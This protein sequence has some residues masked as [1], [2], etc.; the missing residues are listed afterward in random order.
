MKKND[1]NKR[2]RA[3]NEQYQ[4]VRF[5]K[6]KQLKPE[7]DKLSFADKLKFL[8]DNFG[9][10]Y[11]GESGQSEVNIAPSGVGEISVYPDSGN[12][13]EIRFWNEWA[14]RKYEGF[15]NSLFDDYSFPRLK[16]RFQNQIQKIR[17]SN[18]FPD[19]LCRE[20]MARQLK[21]YSE[22][23]KAPLIQREIEYYKGNWDLSKKIIGPS[24]LFARSYSNYVS[25]LKK[26]IETGIP[27]DKPVKT[28][29]DFLIN[30]PDDKKK[31]FADQLSKEFKTEIGMGIRYMIEGLKK[32]NILVT[33]NRQNK[34]LFDAITNY[35]GR[36]IGTYNSV[37]IP[38]LTFEDEIQKAEKKIQFILNQIN[39]K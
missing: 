18:P 10:D 1:L 7:F 24:F 23:L 32:L 6:A 14:I 30:I 11:I 17:E 26:Q 38:K 12:P 2:G 33:G 21:T 19:N 4:K 39:K 5:E 15:K 37:M 16:V 20:Y 27:S 36:N 25:F 29:P 9:E 8:D 22:R 35:F 13:D 3:D 34:K 31:W 28:F